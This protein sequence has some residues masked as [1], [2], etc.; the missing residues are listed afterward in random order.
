MMMVDKISIEVKSS[1]NAQE[2]ADAV[3]VAIKKFASNAA[4]DMT[5]PE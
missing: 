3:L 5:V 4:K 1:G 2:T